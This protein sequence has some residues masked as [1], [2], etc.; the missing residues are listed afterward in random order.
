MSAEFILSFDDC[1]W[2]ELNKKRVGDKILSLGTFSMKDDNEYRLVGR[3]PGEGGGWIH[4]V[5]LFLNDSDIFIEINT[6]PMSIEKDLSLL[7]GW[8]RQQTEISIC[9]EDGGKSNW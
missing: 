1:E 6:H 3:E 2:Y 7:F 8:V 5:R 4:D 9:D